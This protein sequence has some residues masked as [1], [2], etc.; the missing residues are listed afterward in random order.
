MGK[1]N[2]LLRTKYNK[3]K[4]ANKNNNESQSHDLLSQN[5]NVVF[6]DFN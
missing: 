1:T 4:I 6:Y 5:F 3:N 2:E